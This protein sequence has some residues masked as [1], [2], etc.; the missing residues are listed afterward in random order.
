MTRINSFIDDIRN[1]NHALYVKVRGLEP[2]AM[3]PKRI[4]LPIEPHPVILLVRVEGV[5]PPH[6]PI[7]DSKSRASTSSATR[8]LFFGRHTENRT[9]ITGL[10][11][12]YTHRC[13]MC[14]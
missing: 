13:A 9:R 12:P 14:P 5:E 6:L 1:T 10:K 8:A 11:V 7:L 4:A 2:P 3:R